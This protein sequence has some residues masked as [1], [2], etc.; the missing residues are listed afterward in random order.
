M[1]KK[2]QRKERKSIEKKKSKPFFYS[3]L[4]GAEGAEVLGRLGHDV[5]AELFSMVWRV[6]SIEERAGS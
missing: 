1:K 6:E 2:K 3:K 4:T 5:G